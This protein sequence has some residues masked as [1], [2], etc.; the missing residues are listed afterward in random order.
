MLCVVRRTRKKQ[1]QRH[2]GTL[3]KAGAG[4]EIAG[5]RC[6]AATCRNG[7]VGIRCSFRAVI[8][9]AV[10]RVDRLWWRDE[11]ALDKP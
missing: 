11:Q 6:A 4:A 7:D 3:K 1:S 10:R 2:R 8:R 5:K 9:S